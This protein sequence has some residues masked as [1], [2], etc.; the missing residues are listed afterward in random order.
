MSA[1]MKTLINGSP[2]SPCNVVE[3]L[4]ITESGSSD[5]TT[6]FVTF[7]Q[8]FSWFNI[9]ASHQQSGLKQSLIDF[10]WHHLTQ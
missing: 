7:S 1:K 2:E 8:D 9:T 10:V 4:A 3:C 5:S 6:Y